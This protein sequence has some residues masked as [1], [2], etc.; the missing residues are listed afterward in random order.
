MSPFTQL[1]PARRPAGVTDAA[2][3]I[4]IIAIAI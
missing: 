4:A 2:W 3:T 1:A